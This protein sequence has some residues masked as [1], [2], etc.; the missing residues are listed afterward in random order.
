MYKDDHNYMSPAWK[1]LSQQKK[2][3]I[4]EKAIEQYMGLIKNN[5]RMIENGKHKDQPQERKLFYQ[6]CLLGRI[7]NFYCLLFFSY[8]T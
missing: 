6:V 8:L 5:V 4:S 7:R 2:N 1:A 3:F